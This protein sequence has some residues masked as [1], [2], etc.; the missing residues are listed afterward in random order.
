[1][2]TPF[3]TRSMGRVICAP[4]GKPRLDLEVDAFVRLGSREENVAKRRGRDAG[5]M[6]VSGDGGLDVGVG[7]NLV[8]ARRLADTED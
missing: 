4:G 7:G 6:R 8:E 3:R 2:R 1:M 5:C